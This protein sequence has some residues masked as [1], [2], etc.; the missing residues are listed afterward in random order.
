MIPP[1]RCVAAL[2][3]SA[4]LALLVG[5]SSTGDGRD[6]ARSPRSDP[7]G[8]TSTT[9]ATATPAAATT[10]AAEAVVALV[11]DRLRT[12]QHVAAAKAA[13]GTAVDDPERE[14]QVLADVERLAATDEVDAD[15]AR[16]VFEDQIDA[17]KDVQRALLRK[18]SGPTATPPAAPDLKRTVRPVLDAITPELVAALGGLEHHRGDPGCPAAVRSAVHEAAAPAVLRRALPAATAHLCH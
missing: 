17:N 14:R 7:A 18:W 8:S 4:V 9:A 5:C 3:C 6:G 13:T 16:T 11:V 12:A 10:E 15:Y 2:A 1:R